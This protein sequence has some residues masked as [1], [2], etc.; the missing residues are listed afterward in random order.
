[1]ERLEITGYFVKMNL[2]FNVWFLWDLGLL[3]I[4][5]ER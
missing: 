5:S 4:Y 3:A 1:M 2:D